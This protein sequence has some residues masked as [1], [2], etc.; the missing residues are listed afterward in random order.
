MVTLMPHSYRNGSKKYR[1]KKGGRKG[2]NK[3]K[4]KDTKGNWEYNHFQKKD[5]PNEEEKIKKNLRFI[6]G[7]D[8]RK[9]RK[10]I[11]PPRTKE[12]LIQDKLDAGTKISSS[13]K[14]IIGNYNDKENNQI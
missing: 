1:T 10:Y 4:Y 8:P 9:I 6:G 5:K 2:D 13:E 12:E 11:N 14:I 7:F 3:P